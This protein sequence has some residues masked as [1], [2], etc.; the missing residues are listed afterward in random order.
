MNTYG[1]CYQKPY[2]VPRAGRREP[3]ERVCDKPSSLLAGRAIL[4]RVFEARHK[5]RSELELTSASR[6]TI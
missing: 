3:W 1:N 5:R 2:F 4:F 6:S